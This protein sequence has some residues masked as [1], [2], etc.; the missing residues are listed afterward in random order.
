MACHEAEEEIEYLRQENENLRSRIEQAEKHLE[1]QKSFHRKFAEEAISHEAVIIKEFE[2]EK[3]EL[4][5]ELKALRGVNR[6]LK[7]DNDYL[8]LLSKSIELDDDKS[9]QN[10]A[11]QGQITKIKNENTILKAKIKSFQ[12]NKKLAS[13]KITRLTNSVRRYENKSR[14]NQQ[15]TTELND[16]IKKRKTS[17]EFYSS[18]SLKKL[19]E[20]YSIC[21]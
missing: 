7:K 5:D 13:Q 17:K 8:K 6:D 11:T 21:Q 16:L 1:K 14:K 15:L 3:R 10:K 4:E 20:S 9:S 2:R 12:I 19:K 18:D